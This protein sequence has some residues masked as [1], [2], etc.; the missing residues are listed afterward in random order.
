MALLPPGIGK[1]HKDAPDGFVR[2]EACQCDG[3]VLGKNARARRKAACPEPPIH[4]RGPLATDL[5]PYESGALLDLRPLDEKP[6]TPRAHFEL[7]PLATSERTNIDAIA[8]WQARRIVVWAK[9]AS[10]L[11]LISSG[12]CARVHC[13]S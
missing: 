10:V 3:G 12:L 5:E 7:N 8:V 11:A 13:R 2:T 1:V 6:A 4:D 9:H